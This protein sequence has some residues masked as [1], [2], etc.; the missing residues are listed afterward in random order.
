LLILI[1]GLWKRIFRSDPNIV[2]R[3]VALIAFSVQAVVGVIPQLPVSLKGH[4]Q[5]NSEPPSLGSDAFITD[6]RRT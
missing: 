1:D 2:G 3:T 4:P 6:R 5:W